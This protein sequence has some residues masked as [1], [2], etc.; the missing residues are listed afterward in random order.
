[1]N[2]TPPL[3]PR[4]YKTQLMRDVEAM[5]YG[6]DIRLVLIELLNDLGS[7]E[8]VARRL[9]LSTQT[10]RLWLEMLDVVTTWRL[11]ARLDKEKKQ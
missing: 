5:F 1:M 9:G 10:I 11:V 2:A 3:L 4:V 7:L 8:A 6:R